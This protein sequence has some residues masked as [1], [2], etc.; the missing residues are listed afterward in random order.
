MIQKNN[1]KTQELLHLNLEKKAPFFCSA[2][3]IVPADVVNTVYRQA[4][5]CQQQSSCAT[6]FTPGHT[7]LEYIENN[8]K[9]NLVDHLKEFLFKHFVIS[10]LYDQIHARRLTVAGEPRLKNIEINLHKDAHFTFDLTLCDDVP[11]QEWKYFPF[12]APKRKKYKDLDRQVD[13]FV[14]QEKEHLKAQKSPD[15]LHVN[16]WVR[17]NLALFD[18]N[19]NPLLP[20]YK[21]HMWYRVG[22][23]D[24]DT[25]L[26]ELFV[27]KKIG[28]IA[29]TTNR[30]LQEFFSSSITT[31]YMFC[32]EITDIL[33][34]SFFCFDTFKQHFKLKTNK[35]MNQ[36]LIEVFSY[37]ND[38]SL[39][40]SIV[41]E[42][43]HLLL[44][45]HRFDVPNYLILRQQ[46]QVLNA[47][48]KNPD[49]QV[50]RTQKDFKN[51]I[52]RLAEKQVK[53]QIL[54]D[55]LAYGEDMVVTSQDIKCY[56]NLTQRPRT[57][58][59]IYFTAPETKINGQEMPVP[60][61]QLK[62][63]CLR[64]KTLNHIIHHLTK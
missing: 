21:E 53:E 44:S 55:Q 26:Q 33:H 62:I 40:K 39:R 57:K 23:E 1:E 25:P 64:E 17:F 58:E 60:E 8:F 34:N 51:L 30:G 16:D 27:G 36:K 20:E 29:C 2:T 42:T 11:L 56:L 14:K 61:E 15:E 28:D 5:V 48:K 12:K 3:V 45:K 22:D 19:K 41:E 63:S 54:L 24:A 31:S 59:F 9:A 46:E 50:Y 32:V 49:Y 38:L 7:P 37:R 52:Y 13:F 4:S 18:Q 47:V 43:L 6:G 35:E 10:F